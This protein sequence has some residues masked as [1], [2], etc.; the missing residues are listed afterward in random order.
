ME[1]GV[2]SD[3]I[4]LF[5][6][7]GST[8]SLGDESQADTFTTIMRTAFYDNEDDK[9]AF[10][11][12]IP[13]QVLRME[14]S[15]NVNVLH[16]KD[17]Y[18]PRET[19]VQNDASLPNLSLSEMRQ[20]VKSLTALVLTS[21]VEGTTDGWDI[22]VANLISGEQDTGDDCIDMGQRCLAD[23]RDTLCE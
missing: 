9:E 5:S 17:E 4:S 20:A 16:E 8:L 11:N 13:F 12:S 1:S 7:P 18:I 3:R 19:G 21:L 6:F 15:S 23:C 10:F 14:L 2:P 22:S